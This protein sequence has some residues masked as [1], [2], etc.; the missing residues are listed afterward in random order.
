MPATKIQQDSYVNGVW[1]SDTLAKSNF[2]YS[3]KIPSKIAPGAYVS[4]S[5]ALVEVD[6]LVY[7]SFAMKILHCTEHLTLAAL[8]FTPVSN[9]TPRPFIRLTN[10]IF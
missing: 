6:L 5:F 3:V 9:Y 10:D 1:A 7:S 4:Q 2:T 8:S